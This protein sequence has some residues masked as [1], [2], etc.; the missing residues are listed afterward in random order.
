LSQVS[1]AESWKGNTIGMVARLKTFFGQRISFKFLLM[2]SFTIAAIFILLFLWLSSRQERHI[3]EQ[4]KKQAAILHKQI[5]LTRQWVA[6]HN[7]ILIRKRPG[8]SS[9]PYLP[10]PDVIVEDGTVYTKISPSILTRLLSEKA[11]QTD[12]YSFKLT[13]TVRFNPNNVPDEFEAHALKLFRANQTDSIFRTEVRDG[14]HVMRYAAPVY[15]TA[16]CTNCHKAQGFQVGDVG[17]CLSVFVPMDE[18]RKAIFHDKAFLLAGSLA[19]A[20]S[21]VLLLFVSARHLV[22]RRLSGLRASVSRMKLG[23]VDRASEEQGDELKEIADFCY[24]LDGK[25][26]NQHEELEQKIADA[27]EDLSEANRDLEAVNQEMNELNRELQDLNKAKSDFFSDISHELRTPL[28]GIK[29]AADTLARK[30]ACSDPVYIDIIQRNADHL[31]KTALDFLDYS[32][33]ESGQLE[34]DEQPSS[35]RKVAEEAILALKPH[36]ASRSVRVVLAAEDDCMAA[37]DRTR[38][39]QVFSNLLSN[40]IR[41]SP[42]GGSVRVAISAG[43]RDSVEAS[44]EDAGPGIEKKYHQTVFEKFY[45]LPGQDGAGIHKGSSGIGLAICKGLVEAHGGTIRVESEAGKGSRF[46]FSIPKKG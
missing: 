34:L 28:A 27:T 16:Y 4:V 26:R 5:V 46:S 17:G 36:A 38:I 18:A 35:L 6:Q 1:V 42:E 32:K 14:S 43:G 44:V 29:G 22:F 24:F 3:M 12:Q 8:I 37:F 33:I 30:S 9:N 20:G 15:V 40:A 41:F 45:Q 10:E 2:S 31:I 21:L 19:C 13:N 7:A 23:G 25:L 39:Y 11:H